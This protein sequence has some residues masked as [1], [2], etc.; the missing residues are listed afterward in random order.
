MAANKNGW[1]QLPTQSRV[2]FDRTPLALAICQV[3]FPA[4]LNVSNPGTVAPFQA[5]IQDDYPVATSMAQVGLAFS[6]QSG[7][8]AGLQSQA[9]SALWR[10]ADV[11]DDWAVVLSPEFVSIETRAYV[12][13]DDFL[14]R[15]RQVLDALVATVRPKVYTRVG[16]R[17][18]NELRPGHREWEGVVRTELLGPMA[19]P[20]LAE[21]AVHWAQQI[22]LHGPDGN[23]LHVQH[24][25]IPGGSTVDPRPGEE[26]PAE[27][28]FYLLDLDAYREFARPALPEM[29]PL[30]VCERVLSAHEATSQFFRW[31]ITEPYAAT[32]GVRDDASN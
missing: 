3:R 2:V 25:V 29:S 4:M 10:F 11:G 8:I 15:L 31:A 28:S 16:L 5:A 7:Q 19:V 1:L 20:V 9:P 17:Y 13:F 26:L 27:E 6:L 30:G 12:D 22:L 14:D 23:R 24:G 21:C 32:L 18:I